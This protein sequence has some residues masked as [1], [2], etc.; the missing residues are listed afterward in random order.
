MEGAVLENDG[1][2]AG[3]G[4]SSVPYQRL[5]RIRTCAHGFGGRRRYRIWAA[6]PA[7]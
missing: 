3:S 6:D 4:V 2:G 1:L 5:I 7:R